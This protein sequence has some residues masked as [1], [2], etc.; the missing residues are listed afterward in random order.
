MKICYLF[1]AF[2]LIIQ[3]PEVELLTASAKAEMAYGH[4]I[5]TVTQG[6]MYVHVR[7]KSD[8]P[9]TLDLLRKSDGERVDNRLGAGSSVFHFTRQSLPAGSYVLRVKWSDELVEL[10]I[11]IE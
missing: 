4:G 6:R 10:P 5:V 9:F 8:A 7:V 11:L 1:L 3:T 2:S